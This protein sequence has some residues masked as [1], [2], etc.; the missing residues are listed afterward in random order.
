MAYKHFNMHLLRILLLFIRIGCLKAL[1]YAD[2]IKP[3][4]F[5]YPALN[6]WMLVDEAVEKCET[7]FACGGFTFKGSY[8][9]RNMLIEVYFFHVVKKD[10]MWVEKL[11]SFKVFLSKFNFLLKKFSYLRKIMSVN[12]SQRSYPY[13]STYEVE[14]DYITLQN[15]RIKHSK[16]SISIVTSKR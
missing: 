10:V 13:W 1:F 14:R 12:A 5:E 11:K 2:R 15:M 8:T 4:K 9:N 6:G 3:G 16:R 7:D